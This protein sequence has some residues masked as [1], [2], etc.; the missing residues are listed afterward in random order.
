MAVSTTPDKKTILKEL[1]EKGKLKGNLTN[2]EI[3]DAMGEIDFD[4][5]QLEKF[6]DSLE[7]WPALAEAFMQGG[8]PGRSALDELVKRG[9][10]GKPLVP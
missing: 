4:P 3:L 5:E 1:T 6:Y 9:Y 7:A 10:D 8:T 2:K